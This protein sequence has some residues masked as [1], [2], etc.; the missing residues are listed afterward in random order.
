MAKTIWIAVLPDENEALTKVVMAGSQNACMDRVE[1][2]WRK[3]GGLKERKALGVPDPLWQ[4]ND[5]PV[6]ERNLWIFAEEHD[7]GIAYGLVK[8]IPVR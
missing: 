7:S 3:Y 2:E 6:Y 8:R 5:W 1:R 4:R